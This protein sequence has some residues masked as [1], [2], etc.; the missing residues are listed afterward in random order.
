MSKLAAP[1]VAAPVPSVCLWH[2]FVSHKGSFSLITS[3]GLR[4]NADVMAVS[5]DLLI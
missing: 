4:P 3:V 5:L 2:V 1:L